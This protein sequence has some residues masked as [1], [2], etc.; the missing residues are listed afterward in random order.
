MRVA[1]EKY[2]YGYGVLRFQPQVGTFWTDRKM[3]LPPEIKRKGFEPG[4]VVHGIGNTMLSHAGGE[5]M[6]NRLGFSLI[7]VT[8]EGHNEIFAVRGNKEVDDYVYRYL[9]DGSLP[10][11]RVTCAGQSRPDIAPDSAGG[12]TGSGAG[13]LTAEIEEWD[14]ANRSW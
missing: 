1:R 13:T 10:P 4:I 14:A 2:P 9:I 3:E 12:T 8:D 5:A 6:A 7:S 11:K